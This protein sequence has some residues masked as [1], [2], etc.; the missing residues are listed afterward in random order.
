MRTGCQRVTPKIQ[1]N[2]MVFAYPCVII[3]ATLS[4]KGSRLIGSEVMIYF[5]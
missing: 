1:A 2:L 5:Y 4:S 3:A